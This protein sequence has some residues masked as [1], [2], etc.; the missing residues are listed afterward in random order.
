MIDL[1]VLSPPWPFFIFCLFFRFIFAAIFVFRSLHDAVCFGF[2]ITGGGGGGGSGRVRRSGR[3][4]AGSI[5]HGIVIFDVHRMYVV[6]FVFVLVLRFAAH[7]KMG[8]YDMRTYQDGVYVPV[9]HSSS[10][11]TYPN[12]YCGETCTAAR[13]AAGVLRS[14]VAS[15]SPLRTSRIVLLV[16]CLFGILG[17]AAMHP[18]RGWAKS[19]NQLINQITPQQS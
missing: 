4:H 15:S 17:C 14:A 16:C 7:R 12:A 10:Q 9:L 13:R 8:M 6:C 19:I 18:A 11:Y 5:A 3:S 2:P 1:T